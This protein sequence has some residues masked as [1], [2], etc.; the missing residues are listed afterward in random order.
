MIYF[1]YTRFGGRRFAIGAILNYFHLQS[2]DALYYLVSIALVIVFLFIIR[3]IINRLFRRAKQVMQQ[4]GH[5]S[6]SLNFVRYTL[7]AIV[8]FF[9]ITAVADQIPAL[10]SLGTLAK[11]LLAGSGILAVVIGIAGQEAAGNLVSGIM[12][13]I[14]KPFKIGDI[15]RYLDKDISG[16]VEEITLRHTVI[17]TF[18]NKRLIV[19]NGTINSQVVEN[20]DYGDE[21]ICIF[22]DV[23]VSYDSDIEKAMAVLA[24]VIRSDPGFLDNRTPGEI[25]AG[26]P[27]VLVRVTSFA[28]SSI[29]LRGFA[30]AENPSESFRMKSDMLRA[31]K[32]EFDAEGIEIPYP[33]RT[34]ILER[35]EAKPDG[36]AGDAK[37]E[38]NTDMR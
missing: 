33:H 6:S 7:L 12:I 15:I 21:R 38:H 11:S 24:R 1:P 32:R 3:T 36:G 23:G 4:R 26:A 5:D 20:A 35:K 9:C 14:F 13:L 8:Y 27:E 17:R 10:T 37:T 29:Q 2:G 16:V 30:W 34:V 31:V 19:P 22:L 18:E 28:D 25:E